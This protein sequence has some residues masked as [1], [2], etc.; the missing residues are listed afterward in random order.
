MMEFQTGPLL[1]MASDLDKFADDFSVALKEK[2]GIDKKYSNVLIGGMGASVISGI[3]LYD[4]IFNL[5]EVQ[6]QVINGLSLPAWANKNTLFVACS[7][8]GNT[9]ETLEMYKDAVARGID[10][11]SITRGGKLGEITRENGGLLMTIRGNNIQPRSSIGWILGY[12]FAVIED[13]GGPAIR[14][15]LVTLIPK[16]S[17]YREEFESSDSIANTIANRINGSVPVIYGTPSLAGVALRMKTQ[18][19]ENSKSIAFCGV[20]PEFNHN[21]I[22]GWYD[23]SR[24]ALFHVLFLVERDEVLEKIVDT[25]STILQNRGISVDTIKFDSESRIENIFRALLFS[26][27]VSLHLAAIRNVNPCDVSPIVDLKGRLKKTLDQRSV[28]ALRH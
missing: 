26:D 8:S 9:F 25:T 27:Y 11:V 17:K 24:K 23:D 20:L 19:N 2:T 10:T 7:F 1:Q 13:A 5:S 28:L 4:G 18:I 16:L 14:G 22:V 21:E 12:L 15:E 6:I 3:L